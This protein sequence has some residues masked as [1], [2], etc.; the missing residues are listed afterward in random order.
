MAMNHYLNGTAVALKLFRE[1]DGSVGYFGTLPGLTVDASA[2]GGSYID[3]GA[4]FASRGLIFLGGKN[5]GDGTSKNFSR[6]Y[7]VRFQSMSNNKPLGAFGIQGNNGAAGID[8]YVDPSGNLR[9]T[10]WNDAGS[11]GL[12]SATASLSLLINIWY[13]IGWTWNNTTRD[14]KIYLNGVLITTLNSSRNLSNGWTG[15]NSPYVAIGHSGNS[16]NTQIDLNESAFW[17]EIVDFGPSG[18][19]TNGAARTEFLDYTP[20]QPDTWPAVGKVA[21]GT[22]WFESEVQKT[23]TSVSPD[24]SVVKL[25]EGYGEDG[26]EFVG[27]YVPSL[28]PEEIMMIDLEEDLE[29]VVVLLDS[30]IDDDQLTVVIENDPITVIIEEKL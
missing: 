30:D 2:I 27:A 4:T 28:P 23:G 11:R 22:T 17:D 25:G 20:P 29:S 13:D 19:N 8:T 26:T 1:G 9:C 6:L 12:N 10:M 3:M 18:L 7:R 15:L 16:G 21:A 24:T 5:L 14:L